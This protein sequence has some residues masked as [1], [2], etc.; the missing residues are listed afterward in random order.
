M[1]VDAEPPLV[2]SCAES[3]EASLRLSRLEK[4]GR[5]PWALDVGASGAGDAMTLRRWL[6][7]S[8]VGAAV[9]FAVSFFGGGGSPNDDAS[10]AKVVSYFRDHRVATQ[11]EALLAVIGAVLMVLFAVR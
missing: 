10:A 4:C 5:V 7:L 11:V 3:G 9:L 1:D 2:V 8:G 6:A